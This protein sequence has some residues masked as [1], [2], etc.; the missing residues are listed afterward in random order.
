MKYGLLI[1]RTYNLGDD[2]QTLAALQF[3]PRV[4]FFIDRDSPNI[5]SEDEVKTIFNGWF[6]YNPETWF[7][8][9][10]I[11]PLFISFHIAP[12][13]AEIFLKRKSI[14]SYL[15]AHQPIGC[16]DL[17]TRHILNLKD[18]NST[19]SGCLTLTLDYGF[20]SLKPARCMYILMVDLPNDLITLVRNKA[21][22]IG[23][24]VVITTQSIFRPFRSYW[25]LL[26]SRIKK[27]VEK[28]VGAHG[29]D[30]LL[31][32]MDLRKANRYS[33]QYRLLLALR[34][35]IQI[36]NACL[37]ITSR[38][39]VALPAVAL[40]GPTILINRNLNNP[41]FTGLLDFIPHYTPSAFKRIAESVDLM[42]LADNPRLEKLKEL[43]RDLISRVKH[44][45]H[46]L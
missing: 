42:S 9:P 38:L 43:K 13:I 24:N 45:I 40:G 25:Q 5:D 2:I 37:V 39:H 16:R 18:I 22:K 17:F 6:T 3:L 27:L 23:I 44:F 11:L 32:L 28:I 15:R 34:R 1:A 41:K 21:C 4:D 36:A 30:R 46:E 14:V 29:I 31:Y 20:S 26:P 35:I 10:N 8:S 12:H 33:P 19:F 7:P